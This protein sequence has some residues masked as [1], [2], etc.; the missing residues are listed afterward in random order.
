MSDQEKRP[1]LE[2]GPEKFQGEN[3][4]ADDHT[5]EAGNCQPPTF[6][7]L[8]LLL[9]RCINRMHVEDLVDEVVLVVDDDTEAPQSGDDS[10]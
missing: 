8:S 3:N 6:I 4:S 2:R 10:Q 5:D 7:P 1:A 9:S